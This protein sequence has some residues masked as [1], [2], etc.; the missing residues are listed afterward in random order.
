MSGRRALSTAVVW[1][2]NDLRTHD[3]EC[4]TYAAESF[5]RVVPVFVVDP[6]VYGGLS[7]FGPPKTGPF[8]ARFV[9]EALEDLKG[10]LLSLGSDLVVRKGSPG[11]VIPELAVE[12]GAEEV[13]FFTQAGTE[14]ADDE[15]AVF[16]GLKNAGEKGKKAKGS[17]IRT[18]TFWGRTLYHLDDLPHDV[19]KLPNKFTTWRNKIERGEVPI[20]DPYP[21]PASL[22]PLP[23]GLDAGSVPGMEDLGWG[24]EDGVADARAA[25]PFR[26][27]ESA[28]LGRVEEYFWERD[29]LKTYKKTRNGMLGPDYSSKLSP[30]LALG[31]LS[32]RHVY[33]EIK[34]YESERVANKSTYWLVFELLWADYFVFLALKAKGKMYTLGG[35]HGA[36]YEIEWPGGEAEY[37]AWAEGKT[38]FPLVDA[39]IREMNLTGFMS[40]RSRQNVASVLAKSL[41]VDWRRGA[42]YFEAMLIDYDPAANWGNWA[43]VSG[44]GNDPRNRYF[45]IARQ[46]RV[47]DKGGKYV[48]HW[49]P[50]LADVPA[51]KVHDPQR[52]S[53][54]EVAKSGVVLGEHYPAPIINL[55]AS[56]A[57]WRN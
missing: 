40:N 26:G 13:V 18:A 42:A 32:P 48:K 45:N 54:A 33:A 12:V 50:E 51:A 55:E 56:Y 41:G 49:L 17:G 6:R 11:K 57:R 34:R 52:M 38:G 7:E 16:R 3:H 46:S 27:G 53:N 35:L 1:L 37:R 21:V 47:Y 29:A 2:R 28:G 43:Y 4:L 8:R 5:E 19:S 30:W 25:Y 9:M 44:V 15:R 22:P 39:S 20:R 14:E 31:C 23:D 10:S 24:E 36:G